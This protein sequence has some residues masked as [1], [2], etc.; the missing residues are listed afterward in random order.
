ML[1]TV[2]LTDSLRHSN[3]TYHAILGELRNRV[4][5]WLE[6]IPATFPHYTRHGVSHSDAIISELSQVLFTDGDPVRPTVRLSPTEIYV[7]CCAAYLHDIGM[8]VADREKLEILS[9][10]AWRDWTTGEG[11]GARR[12]GEIQN[13]R[14]AA[15]I[16]DASQRHFLADLQTRFLIAEF[17]R[18]VHH[19]RARNVLTQHPTA[20]GDYAFGDPMMFR[21]IDDVC[22]AHGL[23][24]HELE[25]PER[26]PERRTI[27]GEQVNVRFLA[28]L[29][30]IGDLLDMSSERACPML[31]AAASPIP[32]D[33]LGHWSQYRRIV[34][35]V[36]APDRIEIVAECETQD[37][38]RLL[39][40]WCTWLVQEIQN[41][42]LVMA[43][44]V[45]HRGW[46]PPEARI[47]EPGPTIR[48]RPASGAQYKPSRW[49]F[50]LDA[51]IVFDRLIKD[52]Y[53]FPLSF[54]RELLQNALDANRTQM[55]ADIRLRGEGLPTSPTQVPAEWRERYPI[56]VTAT[57][58]TL[59]NPL[60][61]EDE[62][63]SV[64]AV[65]DSGTGMDS[66]IVQRYLLQ[67]GRSF[68]TS[69]EFLDHY[70]FVPTSRFGV[71]FL[72]V[73]ADSDHVTVETYRPASLA[74][75]GP[76]RLTLTGPRAYLLTETGYRG[77]PGTMVAV[78]L[79]ERVDREVLAHLLQHWCKRVEF[80]VVFRADGV[81]VKI[82]PEDFQPEVLAVGEDER[83]A[84]TVRAFT[85]EAEGI[86]G[87]VY[88][89]VLIDAEGESWADRYKIEEL[90]KTQPFVAGSVLPPSWVALHGIDLA[91]PHRFHPDG[92]FSGYRSLC[93]RLDIRGRTEMIPLAR[94]SYDIE[95]IAHN[96]E[97]LHMLEPTY[98][99][100]LGEH[101]ANTGHARGTWGWFYKQR[102]AG[103]FPLTTFWLRAPGLLRVFRDCR[104]ETSS[105]TTVIESSKWAVVL[106]S[107]YNTSDAEAELAQAA[108][109]GDV[110]YSLALNDL[111]RLP[112]NVRSRLL[113]NRQIGEIRLD[114]GCYPTVIFTAAPTG[115]EP[116]IWVGGYD[117][118]PVYAVDFP[119][120]DVLCVNLRR[121][122]FYDAPLVINRSNA[123]GDWLIRLVSATQE[124]TPRID[125]RELRR[126]ISFL[127]DTAERPTRTRGDAIP[128][129]I[130]AW[131]N[132]H[133]IPEELPPP[134]IPFEPSWIVTG[135][136][137]E[138]PQAGRRAARRLS[139]R[140]QRRPS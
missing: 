94:V 77:R 16:A 8:V 107:S 115:W 55:Y 6:Y 51:A 121:T 138:R 106:G 7:L 71:G 75:E 102:L 96:P 88:I 60:S 10:E 33:S 24:S 117:R 85:V 28:L 53:R 136:I 80:P 5:A 103:E 120:S 23:H 49:T 66:D 36:T 58:E 40:D 17:V 32:V 134:V 2:A 27:R 44:S 110:D 54:V 29:L 35:R 128:S 3:V 109:I 129:F 125:A 72:S 91:P 70:P 59:R 52:V 135:R 100:I 114:H 11:G 86:E 22:V 37:E 57:T 119:T 118:T 123:Y 13:L 56:Y 130:E 95:P 98:E 62:L 65:D 112:D 122:Y 26:Y 105:V 87:N 93:A 74:D 83:V 30:R 50:E 20:L 64:V 14:T 12:W 92:H 140:T 1:A 41:A 73:F 25:N 133:G 111:M 21:T 113:P 42:E 63:R 4:A 31:M 104:A 81:E 48:I 68:Y 139:G 97:L 45:R 126:F 19:F 124:P 18:R 82:A 61:G 47:D 39:Q 34:H 137:P 132:N 46:K 108:G 76:I 99:R 84:V 79:R 78:R 101:L 38:H 131:K 90:A 15:D 127:A 67:I 43:R 69:K 9:S 116:L 89:P